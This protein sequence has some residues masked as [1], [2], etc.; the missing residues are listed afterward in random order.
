VYYQVSSEKNMER[1][2]QQI[3]YLMEE[4]GGGVLNYA[5]VRINSPFLDVVR[6]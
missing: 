1:R 4:L 2:G 6:N 3:F 5:A